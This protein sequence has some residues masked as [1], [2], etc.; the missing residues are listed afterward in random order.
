MELHY[1]DE[2]KVA[3]MAGHPVPERNN[4]AVKLEAAKTWMGPIHVYHPKNRVRKLV[5][6]GEFTTA[7]ADMLG[8]NLN[9]ENNIREAA[10]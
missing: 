2:V 1:S 10:E 4:H 5:E 7:Y 8:L 9:D 3:I 6:K